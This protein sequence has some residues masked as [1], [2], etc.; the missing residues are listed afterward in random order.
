MQ[1]ERMQV[2]E[3]VVEE[4]VVEELVV[5]VI[6]KVLGRFG[7]FDATRAHGQGMGCERP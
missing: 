4:I 2:E 1:C 3:L 6:D 7:T 5:E